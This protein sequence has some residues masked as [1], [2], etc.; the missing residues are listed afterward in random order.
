MRLLLLFPVWFTLFSASFIPV[1]RAPHESIFHLFFILFT[2][3]GYLWVYYCTFIQ[4]SC[5]FFL[6]F[7]YLFIYS[8]LVVCILGI[9]ECSSL[10]RFFGACV[11]FSVHCILLFTSSAWDSFPMVSKYK[12]KR[13]RRW[14]AKNQRF[15]F[16][17]S[18]IDKWWCWLLPFLL[19]H[20]YDDNGDGSLHGKNW[21]VN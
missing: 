8:R 12:T 20:Q 13:R 6:L 14:R 16:R 1:S 5:V 19:L 7:F 10:A 21:K 9:L 4:S 15:Y 2:L 3:I 11:F 18:P 17:N